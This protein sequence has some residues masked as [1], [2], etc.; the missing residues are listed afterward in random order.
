MDLKSPTRHRKNDGR[1]ALIEFKMGDD[2]VEQGAEHLLEIERLIKKHNE[3]IGDIAEIRAPDLKI[4]I[5]ATGYGNRLE[6]GV[7]AIPIG[8]LKD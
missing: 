6:N 5:K 4:V 1:Y 3:K 2:R 8:C 7:F